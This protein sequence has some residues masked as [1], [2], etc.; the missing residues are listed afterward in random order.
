MGLIGYSQFKYTSTHNTSRSLF[1]VEKEKDDQFPFLDVLVTQEGGRLL[2]S[3]YQ[4]PT[5]TERY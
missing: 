3:V 1:T 5:H 2:T 4:K